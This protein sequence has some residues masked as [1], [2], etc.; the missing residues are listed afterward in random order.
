M[1]TDD[2]LNA[3]DAVVTASGTATVQTALHGKPMVVVYKLSPMTY[4]IGKRMARVDTY[5]MV[6]LIAG[7]RI[8][9]ELIQ[10]DCTPE[11]VAAEAVALLTDADYR[12]RMIGA[13]QGVRVRLGGPGASDRAAEAVLDVIHSV[14]VS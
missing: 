5:A 14:N 12:G 2:V 8:V 7:E 6:N 9:K 13:L 4:R 3:A 1:Q 10:D 11:A